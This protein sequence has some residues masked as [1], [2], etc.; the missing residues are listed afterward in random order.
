MIINAFNK[1]E[2]IAEHGTGLAINDLVS[3]VLH[4]FQSVV[5]TTIEVVNWHLCEFL[6]EI[7]LLVS[8]GA[9]SVSRSNWIEDRATIDIGL[10]AAVDCLEQVEVFL[11]LLGIW[12][13][14][15]HFDARLD[16]LVSR[17]CF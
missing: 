9:S 16:V 4:V 17:D 6:L 8:E 11:V 2:D 14:L 7:V 13:S 12:F 3:I 5:A 15:E 10:V 1:D